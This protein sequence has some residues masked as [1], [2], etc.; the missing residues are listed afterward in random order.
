[1][2]TTPAIARALGE[3]YLDT[4]RAGVRA[5]PRSAQQLIGPS[6][7][8]LE[9]TRA[10]LHRLNGD[11]A[12]EGP[13]PAWTPAIGTALH[14]YV[15]GF[16]T[17]ASA[18]EEYAGRWLTEQRVTVGT[19]GGKEISG[20]TDLWDEWSRAVIDHKFVGKTK[21]ADARANGPSKQYR[22]QAH[23]Y[24]RGWAR[25]GK[26]PEIVMIA[27]VPRDGAFAVLGDSYL[28]WEP[29]DP[30]VAEAAL[31]RANALHAL[32]KAF[33]MAEALAGF[34]PCAPGSWCDWCH[35]ATP[36]LI[37]LTPTQ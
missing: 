29:Y 35:P 25:E 37:P 10:L 11:R 31:A 19:I 27:Y 6:E 14:A 34:A 3:Q 2:T 16:F 5:H 17:A 23:L 30:A 9:C 32:I 1:M 12:P 18:S 8:G 26:H 4:I 13:E 36:K 24:G 22:V 33:G 7:I 28:W 20:S 21:I 15:E